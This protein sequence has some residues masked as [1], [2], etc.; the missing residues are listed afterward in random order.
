MDINCEDWR[1]R[2]VMWNQT[3]FALEFF[4]KHLPFWKMAPADTLI[5]AEKAYCFA[6]PGQIYA[7]YL[8]NGGATKLDLG[9]SS[10][11]FTI[12]WYNPR[13]GGEL[14]TGTKTEIAGPG[15]VAIDRPPSEPGKDW[16]ALIKLK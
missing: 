13:T 11:T 10:K 1:T 7:V 3:R 15:S 9:N 14:Q 8:P 4:H 5:S 16:V 2:D 6:K 12:K